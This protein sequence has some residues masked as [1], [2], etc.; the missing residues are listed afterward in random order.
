MACVQARHTKNNPK[1]FGELRVGKAAFVEGIAQGVM[2]GDVPESLKPKR[3]VQASPNSGDES[4]WQIRIYGRTSMPTGKPKRTTQWAGFQIPQ[5]SASADG[6]RL[7]LQKA[8]HRGQ[9]YLGERT[10]G[11]TGMNPPRRLTNDDASD[12]PHA[13]TPDS[14]TVFFV[15]DCNG[16]YG[17]FKQAVNQDTAEPVATGPQGTLLPRLSADGAWILYLEVQKTWGASWRLMRIPTSGGAPQFGLE[18]R[19]TILYGCARAPASLCVLTEA[20]QDE[21]QLTLM[22]FDPLKGRGKVL[23]TIE[24]DP[25][26][27]NYGVPVSP[28]GSTVAFSKPGEAEIHIRFLSLSG[29]PDREITV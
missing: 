18:T 9:V 7:T 23:R 1:P 14:K 11:G 15:S 6:R 27:F 28:D 24:K 5:L 13:W 25:S 16:T 10:A 2:A 8:M 3:L 26:A 4:L 12:A 29:G 20:S 19:Q 21:K 22:S 17:I